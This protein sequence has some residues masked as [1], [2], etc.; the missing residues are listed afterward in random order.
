MFADRGG[1]AEPQ[2]EPGQPWRVPVV[3]RLVQQD[4]RGSQDQPVHAQRQ[5]P[6]RRAILPVRPAQPVDV[7]VGH[8]RRDGGHGADHGRRREPDHLVPGHRL[9]PRRAAAGPLDAGR[10]RISE[11]SRKR[12]G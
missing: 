11:L 4:E 6:G 10:G 5:Q 7:R 12:Q 3:A 1:D 8:H 2:H 9:A